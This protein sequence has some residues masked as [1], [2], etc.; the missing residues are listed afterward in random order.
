[1]L[2]ARGKKKEGR[3][4]QIPTRSGAVPLRTATP[5]RAVVGYCRAPDTTA[6]C[7]RPEHRPGIRGRT[8]LS[9]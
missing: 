3:G 5:A 1:M 6:A 4:P 7:P 2:V 9:R 8:R